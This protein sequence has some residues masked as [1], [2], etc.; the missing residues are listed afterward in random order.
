MHPRIKQ[1]NQDTGWQPRTVKL[2]PWED[3]SWQWQKDLLLL[4]IFIQALVWPTEDIS[5]ILFILVGKENELKIFLFCTIATWIASN[6]KQ[7]ITESTS[8]LL[9]LNQCHPKHSKQRRASVWRKCLQANLCVHNSRAGEGEEIYWASS[10][11]S[12]LCLLSFNPP[13]LQPSRNSTQ[14]TSLWL[15]N[16]LTH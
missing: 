7:I 15:L 16:Q 5:V 10:S 14:I 8:L 6:R 1:S 9:R 2:P 4:K 3:N 13:T 11:A 12:P